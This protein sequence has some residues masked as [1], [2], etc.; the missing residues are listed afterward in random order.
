ME[1]GLEIQNPAATVELVS[2]C[3]LR[4]YPQ[5]RE[6]VNPRRERLIDRKM[7]WEGPIDFTEVLS[8]SAN[9]Q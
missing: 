2:E 5:S 3:C 1:K 4:C 6:E 7:A 9:F 8:R